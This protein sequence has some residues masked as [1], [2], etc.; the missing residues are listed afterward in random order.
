MSDPP[1]PLELSSADR[2]VP[3]ARGS[4]VWDGIAVDREA[5]LPDDATVVDPGET[6][7]F[8]G[9][10]PHSLHLTVYAESAVHTRT[11]AATT[12]TPLQSSQPIWI[13]SL[14]SSRFLI[15]VSRTWDDDH[16]VVDYF[17]LAVE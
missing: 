6:I 5:R 15:A 1:E 13:V 4:Y 11:M 7:T 16:S 17:T 2:V 10:L 9:E 12:S 3:G 8:H 14:P